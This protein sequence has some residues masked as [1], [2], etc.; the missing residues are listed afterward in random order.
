MRRKIRYLFLVW[1]VWS[2]LFGSYEYMKMQIPGT[3]RLYKEEAVDVLSAD[4]ERISPRQL[5]LN[6]SGTVDLTEHSGGSYRAVCKLFGI[7]GLKTVQID[8]VEKNEVIP[9]G[10]PVGIYVETDGVFVIGTGQVETLSGQVAE[11]AVNIVKTGDYITCFNGKKITKKDQISEQMQEFTG[12]EVVLG[13]RRNEEDIRVSVTP[14]L[15][16][17]G[18]QLGLWIRDDT[19]GIGTLTYVT[20]NREFGALGHGI[21]DNDSGLLM[22]ISEGKLYETKILEIIK[23]KKGAPGEISGSINYRNRYLYGKILSN[24]TGG[25]NGIANTHLLEEIDASAVEIALKQEVCEGEAVLLSAVD[26]S[27]KEYKIEITDIY[28]GG[29]EVNKEMKFKVTDER[30]LELTGG[31]VQGMSGSP[32]IQNGKLVGAVTHV[33]VNDPTTGY[34]IF[35][36]NMLDAAA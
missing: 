31:I 19:Q 8:V 5:H 9:G 6:F 36:E 26:G 33:L 20:K 25:I 10:I 14:A 22:E 28:V 35:I 32:I 3:L 13:I 11:P 4:Q 16:K 24:S 12:G 21:S 23:G 34:G 15:T 30:L 29:Y 7:I 17:N 27:L 18:W 2:L 1:A